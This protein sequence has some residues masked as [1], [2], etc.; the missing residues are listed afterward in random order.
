MEEIW[1]CFRGIVFSS[2]NRFP[3]YKIPR[4]K[5]DPEYYNKEMERLNAKVSRVYEYNKRSAEDRK[6]VDLKRLS[7][8]LLA[9]KKKNL[10]KKHFCCQNYEMKETAG[11]NSTSI[12]K[13][14]K[15]IGKLFMLQ[16]NDH[17]GLHWK[18]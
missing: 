3:P 15:E 6:Q 1:K 11:L 8:E 14:V 2:I 18:S 10:H 13:R 4:K 5:P 17:Y 12:L 7:K 9:G 16:R